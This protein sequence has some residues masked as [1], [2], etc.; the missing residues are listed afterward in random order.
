MK[1]K[2]LFKTTLQITLI[3]IVII[4]SYQ[5]LVAQNSNNNDEQ[6]IRAMVAQNDANPT[7]RPPVTEQ[8]VFVSGAFPRPIIGSIKNDQDKKVST[9]IKTER[10]NYKSKTRIERLEIAQARDMAYEFGF[11]DLSWDTQDKKHVSF[12]ASYVR[13]WRKLQGEWKVDLFF[14][15]P[16]EDTVNTATNN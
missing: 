5:P 12:E 13:V 1:T 9:N 14:A 15:R 11:S 10:L 4:S 16:N 6:K 3:A 8:S 2:N 7:A